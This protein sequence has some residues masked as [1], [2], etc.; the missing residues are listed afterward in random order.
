MSEKKVHE[1]VIHRRI[2]ICVFNWQV[3]RLAS[4]RSCRTVRMRLAG[5]ARRLISSSVDLPPN[6]LHNSSRDL[7]LSQE[8]FRMSLIP[9]TKNTK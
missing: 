2:N 1:Q 5:N 4:F 9:L 8:L 6:Q 3:D 7:Y